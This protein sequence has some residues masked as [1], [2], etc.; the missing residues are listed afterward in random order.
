T[1]R[2]TSPPLFTHW[3]VSRVAFGGDGRSV[4]AVGSGRA[5]TWGLDP[6]RGTVATFGGKSAI[7]R[8]GWSAAGTILTAGAGGAR[9]WAPDGQPGPVLR[10]Q[11]PEGYVWHAAFTPRGDRVVTCG[12]DGARV[13]DPATGKPV[14]AGLLHPGLANTAAFSSDGRLV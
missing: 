11:T 5:R 6:A 10:H 7:Y 9:L 3:P 1:G 8:V 13:W 2:P 12:G 14:G 4:V